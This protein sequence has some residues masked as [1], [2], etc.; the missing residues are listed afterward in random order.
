[1]IDQTVA[2]IALQQKGRYYT[3]GNRQA[4]E[5]ILVLHGYGQLAYYFLQKFALPELSDYLV[6]APEGPHR[7]YLDGTSGRV[8][9]SW[10]TKEWREQD[11]A[12]N[13]EYL[14]KLVEKLSNEY[15]TIT[16]WNLVGFSQG[17]ATAARF[18]QQASIPFKRVVMWATVFP[19]DVVVP[20]TNRPTDN[21]THF[22]IGIDDPYFEGEKLAEI[23]R[24]YQQNSFEIHTFEGKHTI[25]TNTLIKLF[26]HEKMV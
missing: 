24:Y 9:A 2:T 17:G 12:F 13:Q 26:G 18:W 21:Q 22:V 15:P 11:L 19:P 3:F 7:F 14:Q 4:R 23:I 16:T 10:M 1:M 8:G 6:V 20:L 25:D 5:A